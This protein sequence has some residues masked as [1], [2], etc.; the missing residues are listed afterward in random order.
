MDILGSRALSHRR[1]LLVLGVGHE[2][3]GGLRL[4]LGDGRRCREKRGR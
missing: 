1:K 2:G 4:A 3:H